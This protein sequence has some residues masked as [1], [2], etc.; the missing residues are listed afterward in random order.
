MSSARLLD[1]AQAITD[2]LP[3]FLAQ[4]RNFAEPP[5]SSTGSRVSSVKPPLGLMYH[6]TPVLSLFHTGQRQSHTP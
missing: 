3:G 1:V 2:D 5:H 6:A 4:H